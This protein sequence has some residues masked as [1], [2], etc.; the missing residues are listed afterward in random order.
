[1]TSQSYPWFYLLPYPILGFVIMGLTGLGAVSSSKD[2]HTWVSV[3]LFVM[4]LCLIIGCLLF[5]DTSKHIV[6]FNVSSL[7]IMT[8]I[9][10]IIVV[11]SSIR[12]RFLD[13]MDEQGQD[14]K[15]AKI[16]NF[17]V[18]GL[19]LAS[20][21]VH[22]IWICYRI[23]LQKYTF[24]TG[25]AGEEELFLD[26]MNEENDQTDIGISSTVSD[27][28]DDEKNA[29]DEMEKQKQRELEEQRKYE[30]K[31]EKQ[32]KQRQLEEME[33]KRN[34]RQLEKDLAAN[35]PFRRRNQSDEDEEPWSFF[36]HKDEGELQFMM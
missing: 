11:F 5:Y 23:Y 28:N 15:L 34:Y 2:E 18:F 27:E 26:Y 24:T 29:Q 36:K 12:M 3:V 31:M 7:M 19:S 17:T 9:S 21:L 25:D 16:C 4:S 1:M 10:L 20:F 30:E 22:T 35:V 33:E 32:N 13:I 14:V 8:V 6:Q